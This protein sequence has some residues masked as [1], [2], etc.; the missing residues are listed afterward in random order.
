[1][2]S[3]LHADRGDHRY[4]GIHEEEDQL[5]EARVQ[6]LEYL[7]GIQNYAFDILLLF[8]ILSIHCAGWLWDILTTDGLNIGVVLR[9]EGF[10]KA[11]DT[12]NCLR[13]INPASPMWKSVDNEMLE[14]DHRD[15][16]FACGGNTSLMPSI[17][18]MD[19]E[20]SNIADERSS[21][22]ISEDIQ[23][24][25]GPT[26]TNVSRH[27]PDLHDASRNSQRQQKQRQTQ[28]SLIF[29]VK[30]LVQY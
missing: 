25:L 8:S 6:F 4:T 5:T 19:T 21:D 1:M 18:I 29:Q 20:N 27:F 17:R 24:P 14:N 2:S 3:M 30:F 11:W 9:H 7:S 16:Q 12:V 22:Q 23:K 28:T 26:V 10:M 13:E 15:A